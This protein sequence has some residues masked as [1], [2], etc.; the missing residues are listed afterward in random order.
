MRMNKKVILIILVVVVVAVAF[1]FLNGELNGTG[2]EDAG[3]TAIA[4]VYY[5][6]PGDYFVTN[7]K[8][9]NSLSKI[10]VSLALKG[11]DQTDFLTDNNAVIRACIV[12]I[13]RSHTEE[14]LRDPAVTK[15]I[16]KEITDSANR[17]LEISDIVNVYIS[18]F[19][20]Q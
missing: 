15:T 6:T 9:S 19:V 4:D 14:E 5:F 10:S 8:D 2:E 3:Q 20:I 17:A 11:K 16:S 1:I 12:D 7:I 18:D 13:M